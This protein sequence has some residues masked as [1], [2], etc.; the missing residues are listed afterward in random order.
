MELALVF[1]M[2]VSIGVVIALLVFKT[3]FIGTLRVD[4]SD[5]DEPYMFLE[6]DKGVSQISSKKQVVLRVKLEDYIPHK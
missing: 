5:P 6:L 4:R 1:V 3:Y 2:G